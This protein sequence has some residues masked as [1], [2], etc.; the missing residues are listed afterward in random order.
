MP[1]RKRET[2]QMTTAEQLNKS[3]VAQKFG[4]V[5]A[6]SEDQI[7]EP[8]RVKANDTERWKSL[9][10]V[11]KTAPGQWAMIKEC[12]KA[13]S[14][15]SLTSRINSGTF[16]AFPSAE[17]FEARHKVTRRKGE[18]SEKDEGTSQLWV[19]FNPPAPSVAE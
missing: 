13:G 12:D 1:T 8:P 11:L 3:E 19:R 18:N 14:A 5:F 16:A 15:G 4:V 2:E 10:T 6:T 9:N 7:P 17:G